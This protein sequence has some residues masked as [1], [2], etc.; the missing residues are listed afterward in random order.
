[1]SPIHW[2]AWLPFQA[3]VPVLGW[4]IHFLA[5]DSHPAPSSEAGWRESAL[6][7]REAWKILW[8]LTY[9]RIDT[10]QRGQF[11][12]V[13]QIPEIAPL[14]KVPRV[15]RPI[16]YP[17][18]S[19]GKQGTG[20]GAAAAGVTIDAYRQGLPPPTL[21]VSSFFPLPSSPPSLRPNPW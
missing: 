12:F 11:H 17:I 5:P 2:L 10:P 20:T 16:T 18:H 1:M 15:Y 9:L 6:Y 8:I 13:G 4:A 7:R 19:S 3:P 21:G 14:F